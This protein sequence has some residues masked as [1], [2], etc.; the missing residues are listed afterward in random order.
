MTIDLAKSAQ[1]ILSIRLSADGFSFSIH[2]PLQV[3]ELE[4]YSYSINQSY[5]ITANLKEML[6][7]QEVL[8]Y[9]FK[10]VNVLYDTSRSTLIPLE[11]YNDEQAE[12]LFYQ[13]FTAVPTE[14]VLCNELA[15]SN[16]VM[17]FGIDKFCHQVIMEHFPHAAIYACTSPMLERL[18][19]ES[20]KKIDSKNMYIYI[21][22][23]QMTVFAFDQ[24]K[25]QLFNSFN[26]KHVADQVYYALYIWQQLGFDQQRHELHVSNNQISFIDNVSKY[27]SNVCPMPTTK[28]N[29]DE[30]MKLSYDL[31]SLIACE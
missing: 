30:M 4:V 23:Q 11:Y 16:M 1:Y 25:L 19:C 8:K 7:T 6:S 18:T 9:S 10:K 2:N 20:R 17:L 27:I 24:G 26:C 13:N 15:E 12:Q 29:N 28:I 21:Q 3:E 14:T 31:Q 22:K 5:S